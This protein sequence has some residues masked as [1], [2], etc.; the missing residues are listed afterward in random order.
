MCSYLPRLLFWSDNGKVPKIEKS[1][2]LG[3]NRETLVTENLFSPVTLE[4]DTDARRLYWIDTERE[5]VQFV[6]Y[7]GTERHVVV[8]VPSAALFDIG[9]FRV[10]RH[11]VKLPLKRFTLM[12][13]KHLLF[14][15]NF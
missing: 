13:I 5:E 12:Y 10:S 1:D 7:N 4:A 2:L 6:N 14:R 15:N 11:M 8:R 3:Q 9:I